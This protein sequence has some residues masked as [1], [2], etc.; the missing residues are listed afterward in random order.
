MLKPIIDS[1]VEEVSSRYALVIG[2]A[3]RAREIV[4]D[5]EKNNDILIEKPVS[6]ALEEFLDHDFA[7]G[8]APEEP[9]E[10]HTAAAAGQPAVA[11]DFML[12]DED[13]A[14]AAEKEEEAEEEEEEE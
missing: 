11:M 3:K 1:A 14:K 5:A 7:I 9:G 6:I 10:A 12:D 2:I 8:D 4:E 13:E